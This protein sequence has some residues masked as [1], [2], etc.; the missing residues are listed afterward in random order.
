MWQ[1]LEIKETNLVTVIIPTLFTGPEKYLEYSLEQLSHSPFVKQILLINNS[2]IN[3]SFIHQKL[4][5]IKDGVNRY[6]N[7]AWNY[8]VNKCDTEF[9]LLLNDDVMVSKYVLNECFNLFKQKPDVDLI[10][11]RTDDILPERYIEQIEENGIVNAVNV[12]YV[13]DL[14]GCFI[15]GRKAQWKDIPGPLN[16]FYGDDWIL[17]HHKK[18]AMII[19]STFINHKG[20]VS[21]RKHYADGTLDNEGKKY[22]EFITKEFV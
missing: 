15:M 4:T 18:N 5:V 6:V 10:F 9:Y 2:T 7:P 14:S 11:M 13:Q 3:Y 19:T 8:G 20:A 21:A 12:M 1:N 17:E 16:I 22:R